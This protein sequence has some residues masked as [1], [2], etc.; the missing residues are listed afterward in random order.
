MSGQRSRGHWSKETTISGSEKTHV[1]PCGGYRLTVRRHTTGP[2][3]WDYSSGLVERVPPEGE[4]DSNLYRHRRHVAAIHRNYGAFPFCWLTSE[5]RTHLA[6]GA[7]Y[8][9]YGVLDCTTGAK[10]DY[11]GGRFCHSSLEWDAGRP[12]ELVAFGCVWGWVCEKIVYD[13]SNPFSF[14]WPEL[15]REDVVDEPEDG[16]EDETDDADR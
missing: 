10:A 3:T 1:S 13:I 8:Q 9:G 15:S 14:P 2:V 16:P 11:V 12:R 4:A 6:Y 5:G 7:D